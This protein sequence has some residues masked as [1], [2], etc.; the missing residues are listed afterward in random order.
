[1]HS[2]IDQSSQEVDIDN[3]IAEKERMWV[4]R[5]R[6]SA[7]IV[8]AVWVTWILFVQVIFPDSLPSSW[9]IRNDNSYEATG[10]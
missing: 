6:N 2:L 5:A 3:E 9:Y 10:W 8:S 4:K 1:M 7:V